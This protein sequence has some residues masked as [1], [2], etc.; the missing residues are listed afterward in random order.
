MSL[1]HNTTPSEIAEAEADLQAWR[2]SVMAKDAQVKA[3]DSRGVPHE[4][5]I[6][7]PVRG[8][9]HQ[10]TGESE[11]KRSDSTGIHEC[12]DADVF[13]MLNGNQRKRLERLQLDLG[14]SELSTVKRQYKASEF[15]ISYKAQFTDC[16]LVFTWSLFL[17]HRLGENERQ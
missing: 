14:V 5:K 9:G 11:T 13:A 1:S 10:R 3:G 17:L 4:T 6:K 7:A 8:A 12:D 16:G 2:K 15:T